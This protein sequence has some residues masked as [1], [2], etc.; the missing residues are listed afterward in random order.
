[1]AKRFF[2]M[3]ILTQGSQAS[4]RPGDSGAEATA[5]QTLGDRQA[6]PKCAKR[7]G[8]QAQAGDQLGAC[9]PAS[10]VKKLLGAGLWKHGSAD[11]LIGPLRFNAGNVP[12]GGSAF[13]CLV[14]ALI[15]FAVAFA[16]ADVEAT[17]R[18]PNVTLRE[19]ERTF[20]L[21]NGILNVRIEK[22]SGEIFS[23]KYKGLEMLAQ[24]SPGGAL[25]GYWSSV[26]RARPGGRRVAMVRIDPAQNG[27]ERGEVSCAF[28]N[29][30]GSANSPL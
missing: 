26:G 24:E 10:F 30:A 13:R 2:S 8:Q 7:L 20:F 17:H 25:G 4:R 1:M 16:R 15:P 18:A 22:Q 6:S 29:E 9:Q 27:G 23:I 3:L 11:L 19:S 14:C 12:I 28:H 21:D 5:V